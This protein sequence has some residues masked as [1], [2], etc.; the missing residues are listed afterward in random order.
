MNMYLQ[1]EIMKKEYERKMSMG[2]GFGFYPQNPMIASPMMQFQLGPNGLVI[3]EQT[4][5]LN[6]GVPF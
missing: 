2:M 4:A 1:N 5:Y 6:A 3:D